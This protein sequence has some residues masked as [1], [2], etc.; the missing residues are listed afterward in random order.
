MVSESVLVAGEYEIP[1]GSILQCAPDESVM[2]E[3]LVFALEEREGLIDY[4][5]FLLVDEIEAIDYHRV[6]EVK[7]TVGGEQMTRRARR[8]RGIDLS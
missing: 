4:S 5:K 6:I 8:K 1:E 7:K 2:R 3:R